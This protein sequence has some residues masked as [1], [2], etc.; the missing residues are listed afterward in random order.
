MQYHY[1]VKSYMI[2][3]SA[4]FQMCTFAAEVRMAASGVHSAS[5]RHEHAFGVTDS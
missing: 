4:T 2:S 5:D 1:Y 3:Y